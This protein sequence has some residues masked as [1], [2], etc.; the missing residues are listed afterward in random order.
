MSQRTDS[1]ADAAGSGRAY[2]AI[3]VATAA[4]GLE[5]AIGMHVVGGR[6]SGPR[7][8]IVSTHHGDEIFTADLVRRLLHSLVPEEIAGTLYGIPCAIPLAFE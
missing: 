2:T 8:G 6:Q 1:Q 4:S 3:P 7:V 5:L